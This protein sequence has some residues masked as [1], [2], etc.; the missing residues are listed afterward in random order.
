MWWNIAATVATAIALFPWAARVW[1]FRIV[2]PLAAAAFASI[3]AA[4]AGLILGG[5]WL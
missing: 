2:D 4:L 3:T 5:V 1:A